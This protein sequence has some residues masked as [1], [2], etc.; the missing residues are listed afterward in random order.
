[1]RETL[2][3]VGFIALVLAILPFIVYA[4]PQVVGASQSYVV[5]SDS[6]APTIDAGDVVIVAD[7]QPS[8]IGEGDVITFRSGEADGR[9][10]TH[11]VIEVVERDGTRAFRTKGDAN[12]DPDPE[13]VEPSA[14]VGVVS[15][16]I[17]LIGRAVTFAGTTAGTVALVVVPGLL[18]VGSELYA[19]LRDAEEGASGETTE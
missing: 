1:M 10:V 7:R 11:R 4:V 19:L 6:M 14:V 13:L 2:Q 8:Q 5:L 17:P 12:E 9:L 18:L 15:F 3:R 16:H